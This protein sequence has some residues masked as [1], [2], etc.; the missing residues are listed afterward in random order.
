MA[1]KTFCD[2]CGAETK[3][4]GPKNYYSKLPHV[5]VPYIQITVGP[6]TDDVPNSIFTGDICDACAA[7]I[8]IELARNLSTP[9]DRD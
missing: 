8:I 9:K 3:I 5:G 7:K 2:L 1:V 6:V 4:L